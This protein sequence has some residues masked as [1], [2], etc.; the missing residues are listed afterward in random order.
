MALAWAT[1][2]WVEQP[3]RATSRID[4]SRFATAG[5]AAAVALAAASVLGPS[6]A[7]PSARESD[8]LADVRELLQVRDVYAY[9]GMKAALRE[10]TCHSVSPP[11]LDE[12]GCLERRRRNV[13]LWG[14][15]YAASLF[16]GLERVRTS[17]HAEFGLLQTTDGNG[18]PFFGTGRTDDGKTLE[19]ANGARLEIARRFQPDVLVIA[20]MIDG[21][22]GIGTKEKSLAELRATLARIHRVSPRSRVVV[23]G[24]F[25]HWSGTLLKQMVNFR[26][27]EGRVAPLYMDQGLLSRDREW[28]RYFLANIKRT[29]ATYISAQ[30]LMCN[31][32]GCLTRTGPAPTELTAVDWGHLT[33]AGSAYFAAQVED[34]V[35]H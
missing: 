6:Q 17:R 26:R 34:A 23:I 9:F 12:N 33:R 2:R 14:D 20:W 3:F 31:E 24:P 29:E 25:P 27:T 16:Y 15:S 8:D 1:W 21:L 7:R 13:Q 4:L 11:A 10:G 18:P 22:N 5:A 35:F 28:D 30:D 32:Q 19:E